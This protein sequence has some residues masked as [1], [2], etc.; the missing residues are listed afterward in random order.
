MLGVVSLLLGLLCD[1]SNFRLARGS[2]QNELLRVSPVVLT[3]FLI[4]AFGLLM[5]YVGFRGYNV[6]L[7]LIGVLLMFVLHVAC[8]AGLRL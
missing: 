5:L 6:L 7:L 8:L 3:P 4:N 1:Y 2:R